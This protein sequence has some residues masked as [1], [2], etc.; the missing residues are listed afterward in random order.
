MKNDNKRTLLKKYQHWYFPLPASYPQFLENYLNDLVGT[1]PHYDIQQREAF[2]QWVYQSLS[3][4]ILEKKRVIR[5]YKNLSEFQLD[6]LTKVFV[7]EEQKFIELEKDHPE[8]IKKLVTR[9]GFDWI[10]ILN[11]IDISNVVLD[12]VYQGDINKDAAYCL[13]KLEKRELIKEYIIVFE[14]LKNN[15]F[16]TESHW[17]TYLN[18]LSRENQIDKLKQLT[19]PKESSTPFLEACRNV[20][21]LKK[22]SFKKLKPEHINNV[23]QFI[24]N[25]QYSHVRQ[26]FVEDLNFY[27]LYK[28]KNVEKFLNRASLL[29]LRSYDISDLNSQISFNWF[30]KPFIY[31]FPAY[32]YFSKRERSTLLDFLYLSLNRM[33]DI[34][35][36]K[37]G[38]LELNNFYEDNGEDII[39]LASQ[40]LLVPDNQ[41]RFFEIINRHAKIKEQMGVQINILLQST[42]IIDDAYIKS[43]I[44]HFV[45]QL[46]PDN[47]QIFNSYLA[48]NLTNNKTIAE[49]LLQKNQDNNNI[50]QLADT[51]KIL[52]KGVVSSSKSNFI[53]TKLKAKV[54][55]SIEK[56][57]LNLTFDEYQEK[58]KSENSEI[59]S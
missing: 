29:F 21:I 32:I 28:S 16:I 8:D 59:D 17:N 13:D 24:K 38:Q 22:F 42:C 23:L 27:Y 3:L 53:F 52:T 54:D 6:E 33:L 48:L 40:L 55:D 51:L 46:A 39:G 12:L 47:F 19:I 26:Q 11:N 14:T 41:G 20:Y 31:L 18:Y 9:H 49:Y 45:D 57:Q 35:E 56:Y 36:H 10:F 43:N 7:E 2:I 30:K 5:E 4:S 37:K 44:D 50:A 1:N 34:I 58:I 25:E 15:E